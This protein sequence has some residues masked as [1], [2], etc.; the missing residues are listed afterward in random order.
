MRGERRGGRRGRA[1]S[2]LTR[3]SPPEQILAVTV[4]TAA[5]ALAGV[6]TYRGPFL[7][8]PST[9]LVAMLLPHTLLCIF[10]HGPSPRGSF[11]R[12]HGHSVSH[13]DSVVLS[14]AAPRRSRRAAS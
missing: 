13:P 6:G 8:A 11:G 7:E 3:L 5:L 12:L 2:C 10:G 9:G 14:S 4:L 1:H